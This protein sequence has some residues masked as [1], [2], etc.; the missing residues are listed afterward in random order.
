MPAIN[1]SMFVPIVK[2]SDVLF[3]DDNTIAHLEAI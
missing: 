1:F 3:T 2:L